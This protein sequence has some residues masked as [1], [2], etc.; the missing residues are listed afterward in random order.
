M[1][2]PRKG[3]LSAQVLEM[4]GIRLEMNIYASAMQ[5]TLRARII[6]SFAVAGG[7]MNEAESLGA[8]DRETWDEQWIDPKGPLYG[9]VLIWAWQARAWSG[10]DPRF[11]TAEVLRRFL[12]VAAYQRRFDVAPKTDTKGNWVPEHIRNSAIDECGRIFHDFAPEVDSGREAKATRC[13]LALAAVALRSGIEDQAD[14]RRVDTAD[15]EAFKDSF[16][17]YLDWLA[18]RIHGAVDVVPRTWALVP[19][20]AATVGGK[21]TEGAPPPI[22]DIAGLPDDNRHRNDVWWKAFTE[23]CGQVLAGR[24][25]RAQDEAQAVTADLVGHGRLALPLLREVLQALRAVDSFSGKDPTRT[26][27]DLVWYGR[28]WLW[29]D[30]LREIAQLATPRTSDDML[31]KAHMV[32]SNSGALDWF[33]ELDLMRRQRQ[34]VDPI[35]RTGIA[36][37]IPLLWKPYWPSTRVCPILRQAASGLFG[38]EYI[39]R[40]KRPK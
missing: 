10:R 20:H 26:H 3:V 28:L 34:S 22:L 12:S 2:W 24:A 11:L 6:G 25:S 16:V 36:P 4:T 5:T 40:G 30:L 1:P 13:L 39:L 15:A 18:Y 31:R 19:L 14:V 9:Q 32:G 23:T 21:P 8:R 29:L 17:K 27:R 7:K 33:D 35:A 37:P 38:P